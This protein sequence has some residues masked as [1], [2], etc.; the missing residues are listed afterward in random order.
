[1]VTQRVP[2]REHFAGA[3]L[4]SPV[5]TLRKGT[6]T[7]TCEAWSHQFGFELRLTI[8]DDDLPRTQ[9]CPSADDLVRV[10]EDWRAALTA[11]G[12]A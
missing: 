2:Q 11:K 1:M 7:A 9:T 4:L 10:Q 5:W 8:D 6:K 3:A 12:W